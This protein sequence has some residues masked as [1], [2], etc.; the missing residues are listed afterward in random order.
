MPRARISA[1]PVRRKSSG[2]RR[3]RLQFSRSG[4]RG[5][6]SAADQRRGESASEPGQ[7]VPGRNDD[8]I[9]ILDC[10]PQS[11]LRIAANYAAVA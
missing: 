3:L 8:S 7:G 4:Y 6:S 11:S 2:R 1:D 9:S 5:R 10:K